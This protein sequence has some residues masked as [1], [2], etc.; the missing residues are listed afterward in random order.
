M[1]GSTPSSRTFVYT[2]SQ[3]APRK[4]F[5]RVELQN[6]L[7]ASSVLFLDFVLLFGGFTGLNN[8]FGIQFT[9]ASALASLEATLPLALLITLTAF[10]C[11]EMAHKFTAQS[12]GLWSE[13]RMSTQGLLFSIVF[14]LFGFLWGAPGATVVAGAREPRQMGLGSF[15]GPGMN[16]IWTG[17]FS[18]LSIL[19]FHYPGYHYW[20]GV[21]FVVAF[22][23][24]WFAIFNL[25]PWG[26]L[27][28]RKVL[29]WNHWVW[30]VTFFGALA[31]FIFFYS[32]YL[33]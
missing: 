24:L 23:N 5:S 17:V 1:W 18:G 8:M 6:I 27:D 21:F 22:V 32:S 11:H 26:P 20:T 25:I 33:F 15:A 3:P 16:L 12:M 13:F 30:G 2:M 10:L 7:I 14:S 28:G 19:P 31:V 29:R 4:G 9:A